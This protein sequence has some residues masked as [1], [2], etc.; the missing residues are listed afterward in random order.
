M[1]LAVSINN[2][3][4]VRI[5]LKASVNPDIKDGTYIPLCTA[6]RD[7][8][9]DLLRLLLSNRA[10]PKVMAS[11]YPT[12]KCVTHNRLHFLLI[13]VVA[14]VDLHTPKGILE[15]AVSSKNTVGTASRVPRVTLALACSE[16]LY[17]LSHPVA[18]SLIHIQYQLEHY[19]YL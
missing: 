4:S 8:R 18:S 1:E 17:T 15:Q 6:T 11:E 16:G 3:E 5:L 10:D 19:I 13:L 9:A 14:G 7:D 12:F 2:I